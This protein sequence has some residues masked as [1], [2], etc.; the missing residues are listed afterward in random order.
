MLEVVICFGKITVSSIV[1]LEEKYSFVRVY[2]RYILSIKQKKTHFIRIGSTYHLIHPFIVCSS[3]LGIV[4]R[5][6]SPSY[7]G[8]I[9]RKITV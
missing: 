4:V 3:G 8:V 7:L 6:Y 5:A 2:P 1:N 9:G